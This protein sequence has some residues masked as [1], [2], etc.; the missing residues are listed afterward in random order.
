MAQM[1]QGKPSNLEISRQ[2]V[3]EYPLLRPSWWGLNGHVQTLASLFVSG[4]ESGKRPDSYVV[5]LSDGDRL[6]I[7]DDAASSWITGD[8]IA[9]LIHGLCGSHDSPYMRRIAMRLRRHGIRTIRVDMRGFGASELISR[10]HLHAGC[11]SDVLDVIAYVHRLSP[12]SR[13]SLVGFSLGANIVLKT[14]CD[15]ADR[16]PIHVDS[17]IAVSPPTDLQFCSVNLR[18]FGNR[19]YEYYFVSRLRQTLARRRQMVLNLKDNGLNPLP[20]RLVH[21]DDQFTAP[22]NGFRG[23]RDYYAKCSTIDRLKQIYISTIIVACE[24]DPVV[25]REIFDPGT[26]STEIEFVCLKH[27]GHLG[28][29]GHHH[30]DPDW[31]WLDWRICKWLTKL[32]ER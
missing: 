28:F 9:I 16:H 12:L 13:I 3:A 17:A 2:L 25:P 30:R 32:D 31:H 26:F 6:V 11:S 24:D 4:P 7:H 1:A 23:A 14:L 20:D 21:F 8:R 22:V 27:G 10:G 19:F 18:E 29:L 5:P 15:W